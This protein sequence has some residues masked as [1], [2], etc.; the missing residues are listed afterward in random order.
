[1]CGGWDGDGKLD[2]VVGVLGGAFTPVKTS[3]ANLYE[4]DQTAPGVWSVATTHVLDGIDLGAETVPAF[5]DIDGDGDVDLVVGTKIEPDNH[6][7]GG[8]DWFE[9]IGSR[10]APVFRLRESLHGLPAFHDP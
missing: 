7:T 6:R 1:A 4:L 8:P 9:N 3:T 2:R 5:A 10:T